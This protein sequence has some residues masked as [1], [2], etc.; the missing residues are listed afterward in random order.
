M[1]SNH[2]RLTAELAASLS[3]PSA[4]E[5]RERIDDQ[6]RDAASKAERVLILRQQPYADWARSAKPDPIG[7]QVM[8]EL[9][10]D[11]FKVSLHYEEKQFVDYGLKIEW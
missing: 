5:Y 2:E 4:D 10:D 1:T 6:I 7:A 8:K 11:G 3:G 9:R